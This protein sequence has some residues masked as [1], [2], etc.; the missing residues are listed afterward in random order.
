MKL[1]CYFDGSCTPKNPGGDMGM[2]AIIKD[3]TG[4]VL[5]NYSEKKKADA[6][7]SNNVAEYL[8]LAAVLNW[9][10]ESD[11]CNTEVLIMGDS[12]L[13]IEQMSGRW[14]IKFGMYRET[15]LQCR[16]NLQFLIAERQV[17]ITLKWIPRDQN[18]EA[19]LLSNPDRIEFVKP[20]FKKIV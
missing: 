11:T 10:Y 5:L 9:L 1:T 14:K 8:A 2:G 12:N 18:H 15:A 3:E 16:E 4:K 7:N 6:A 17:A 20:V 19:D 13:V